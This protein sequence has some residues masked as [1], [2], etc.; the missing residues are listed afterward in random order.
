MFLDI[1][2]GFFFNIFFFFYIVVSIPKLDTRFSPSESCKVK[3]FLFHEPLGITGRCP[4]EVAS[5]GWR[6][7]CCGQLRVLSQYNRP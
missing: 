3:P 5:S 7:L 6:S 2:L 4:P 1:F